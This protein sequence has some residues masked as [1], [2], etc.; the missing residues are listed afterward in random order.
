MAETKERT[1]RKDLLRASGRITPREVLEAYERTGLEPCEGWGDGR[2]TGCAATAVF[3]LLPPS[4]PLFCFA[5]VGTLLAA[6]MGGE[7]D[8]CGYGTGFVFGFDGSEDWGEDFPSWRKGWRDGARCRRFVFG[9][10]RA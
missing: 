5:H 7:S 8:P 4:P 10:R 6:R 2:E 9:G 1:G 3:G